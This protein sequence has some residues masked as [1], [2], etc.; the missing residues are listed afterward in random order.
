MIYSFTN[1]KT[2][3]D[4][5]MLI[6]ISNKEKAD[7]EFRKLSLTRQLETSED[8]SV[9][10]GA[11]LQAITAELVAKQSI[12]GTLPE[13]KAKQDMLLSIK[14]LDVLKTVFENRQRNFGVVS[15]LEKEYDIG[16]I[17]TKIG[18]TDAFITGVNDR[19]TQI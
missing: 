12:V 3:A 8:S 13:G 19:K 11:E 2:V 4:C 7:L 6:A 17:E 15:R 10:V 5:D 9:E 16:C 14:R 1:L 18:E